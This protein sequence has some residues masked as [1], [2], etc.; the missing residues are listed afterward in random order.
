MHLGQWL[1]ALHQAVTKH[2]FRQ[3]LQD[4]F[5]DHVEPKFASRL[6]TL[7]SRA[8]A[9]PS[10]FATTHAEVACMLHLINWRKLLSRRRQL[11]VMDP[12]CGEG[13]IVA[14]FQH[15]LPHVAARSQL[16]TNDVN[17]EL[18]AHTHL[19]VVLAD[20]WAELPSAVDV[21]VTS[22]PFEIIDCILPPLLERARVLVALHVPGDYISNGP[23][24][25][26]SWWSK[27]QKQQRAVEVR[28]LPRAKGRPTRR[29]SWLLIF[30]T[31]ALRHLLWQGAADCV[32]L[33]QPE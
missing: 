7:W 26:R 28:G 12:C 3:H 22:P 25:R 29:C 11:V 24:Y 6:R 2:E 30:S 23:A 1:I 33:Q 14:A 18:P 9:N 5:G 32:T 20:S 4:S 27:L 8:A 31:P 13:S 15:E 17:P 19:D 16:L 10:T 21:F